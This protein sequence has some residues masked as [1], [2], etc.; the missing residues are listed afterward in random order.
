L[1]FIG[2]IVRFLRVGIPKHRGKQLVF[3]A[4]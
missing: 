1:L 3:Y 4:P 2:L